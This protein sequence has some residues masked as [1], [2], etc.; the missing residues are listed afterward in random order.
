VGRLSRNVIGSAPGQQF[1]QNHSQRVNVTGRGDGLALDLLRARVLR[2]QQAHQA[3]RLFA[4]GADFAG[5]QNL[6]DPK[7]KQLR[8][9]FGIDQYVPWFD[10]A[11]N[12]QP[13]MRVLH[14]GTNLKKKFQPLSRG[15]F[16][17]IAVLVHAQ[18]FYELHHEKGHTLGRCAPI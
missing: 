5:C 16:E 6:G 10:I 2:R 18:T 9:S 1:I 14:R 12:N 3:D 4:F 7:I 11:M 8:N 13:L 15:E 17:L